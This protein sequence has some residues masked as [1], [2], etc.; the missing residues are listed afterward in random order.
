MTKHPN[1]KDFLPKNK[2]S[3]P[4]PF[5]DHLLSKLDEHISKN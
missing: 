4:L 1:L 2:D 3:K 5:I